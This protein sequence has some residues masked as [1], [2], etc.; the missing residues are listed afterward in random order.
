MKISNE[1]L[2][3]SEENVITMQMTFSQ[4]LQFLLAEQTRHI[5]KMCLISVAMTVVP[6]KLLNINL[7]WK[8]LFYDSE[9]GTHA[10][11]FID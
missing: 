2:I 10:K 7:Y 3:Y 9:D 1:Q 5:V 11:C 6:S 4:D 8:L